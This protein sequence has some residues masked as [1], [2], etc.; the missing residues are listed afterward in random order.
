MDGMNAWM[1]GHELMLNL[2]NSVPAGTKN[3]GQKDKHLDLQS[4]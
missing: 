2:I 1:D 3:I 4:F